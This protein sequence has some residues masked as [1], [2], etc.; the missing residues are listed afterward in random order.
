MFPSLRQNLGSYRFHDD[1]KVKN[2]SDTIANKTGHWPVLNQH[3]IGNR[4][5]LGDDCLKSSGDYMEDWKG[6]STIK[7]ELFLLVLRV[8]IS[9]FVWSKFT[10]CRTLAGLVHIIIKILYFEYF[11]E[12]V[13]WYIRIIWTNKMHYFLLIYF[14]KKPLHVSIR[15]A[16]SS[17]YT[18]QLV[19][20]CVMLT[21]CW[22]DYTGCC[23]YR[24]D[25]PDDEQQACSKHVEAYYWNKLIEN[26]A[27]CRFILYYTDQNSVLSPTIHMLSNSLFTKQ[28]GIRR[29]YQVM[30]QNNCPPPSIKHIYFTPTR[31]YPM[32]YQWQ[33]LLIEGK[34]QVC[35]KTPSIAMIK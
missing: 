16:G 34:N 24:V 31:T 29:K 2:S 32:C 13:F 6:S 23:L 19:W 25:P 27:S 12:G 28:Q 35:I 10:A 14:S 5:P 21:G 30:Q 4:H 15:F 9:W 1:C 7:C 3:G 18:Q 11:V 22:H 20:P 17:P 8:K 33:K 26:S